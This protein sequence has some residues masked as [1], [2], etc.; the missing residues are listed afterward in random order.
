MSLFDRFD[1]AGLKEEGFREEFVKPLLN[2]MGFLR[3]TETHG[4]QEYGKDFVFSELHRLGGMRHYAA[5]V[6]HERAINQ[7]AIIDKLFAQIGQAFTRPFVLPDSPR[8]CYVSCVY[9]FNSGEITHNAIEDLASRLRRSNFGDNVVFLSGDRLESLNNYV[10]YQDDT[11][12]VSRL[13]GLSTE[14]GFNVRRW[15]DLAANL[16]KWDS[17]EARPSAL[18]AVQWYLAAPL[19]GDVKMIEDLYLIL[20]YAQTIEAF[21]R[22]GLTASEIWKTERRG[23]VIATC[24][25][26]IELSQHIIGRITVALKML[27]ANSSAGQ[28][29]DPLI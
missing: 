5:Q 1:A 13:V 7:G 22:A 25:S 4:S 12:L 9:V 26:A 18:T 2:R 10:A 11:R 24:R 29:N 19:F 28:L 27:N 21:C 16:D 6:K 14:L 23:F 15:T 20:Q 3:V 8:E 17:H